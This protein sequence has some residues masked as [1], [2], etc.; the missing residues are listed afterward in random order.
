[1]LKKES[2]ILVILYHCDQKYLL[3]TSLWRKDLF[4]LIIIFL[5]FKFIMAEKVWGCVSF[6][7]GWIMCQSNILV[8]QEAVRTL[9]NQG[10]IK[11]SKFIS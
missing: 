8:T 5:R 10:Q 3:K 1:M 9:W 7:G 11:P 4:G 6:Y 2:I